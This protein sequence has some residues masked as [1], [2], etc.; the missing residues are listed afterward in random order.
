MT[1]VQDFLIREALPQDAKAIC[2][3][4][5]PFVTDSTVSFEVEP[6]T[7]VE[8][9]KRIA[10]IQMAYPYFVVLKG[11]QLVGYA[12]ASSWRSRYA[13]RFCAETTIYMAE[14]ARGT[15]LGQH[16]Y[17]ALLAEL[18]MRGFTE[19]IAGIGGDNPASEGFHQKLGFEFVG[20]FERVGF[21][22][23]QWLSAT[24]YQCSLDRMI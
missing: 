13:Y 5:N 9:Q 15:G 8:M 1:Q 12:Y 22:F 18:K 2:D 11:D 21:K 24:F 4:Y 6:V 10:D 3:I 23:D 16:L 19:A 17:K 20:R 14:T 7:V